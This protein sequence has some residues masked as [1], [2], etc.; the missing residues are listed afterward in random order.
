MNNFIY[1][2]S[3]LGLHMV[4]SYYALAD[5]EN[6]RKAFLRL[7]DVHA[8]LDDFEKLVPEVMALLCGCI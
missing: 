7:L 3:V 8:E 5:R 4:L 1:Y 2:G 6:M